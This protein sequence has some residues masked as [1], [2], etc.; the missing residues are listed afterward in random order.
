VRKSV[1]NP[2]AS[3]QYVLDHYPE[4]TEDI[5]AAAD[6]LLSHIK[7]VSIRKQEPEAK[8]GG[9]TEP[10]ISHVLSSRLSS[11]PKD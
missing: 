7:G 8:N 4:R 5:Q 2:L 1:W 3:I 11:R 10:H 9:A 6:Y